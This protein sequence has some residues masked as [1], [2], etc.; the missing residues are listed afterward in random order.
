MAFAA[1]KDHDED[2]DSKPVKFGE[3]YLT[4]DRKSHCLHIYGDDAKKEIGLIERFDFPALFALVI[5]SST[6]EQMKR[7][8]REFKKHTGGEDG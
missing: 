8:A 4:A 6:P 5:E 2:E 7:Y 1:Y 3:I